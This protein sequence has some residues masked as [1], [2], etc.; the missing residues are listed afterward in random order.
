MSLCKQSVL[1][2]ISVMVKMWTAWVVIALLTFF[3]LS[4]INAGHS[5]IA[6]CVMLVGNNIKKPSISPNACLDVDGAFCFAVF[7]L[8]DVIANNLMPLEF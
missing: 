1:S 7:P 5:D 8:T 3:F 2:V 4:S 6:D